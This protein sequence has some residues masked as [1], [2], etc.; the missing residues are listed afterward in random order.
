MNNSKATSGKG[1]STK[2]QAIRE[3]RRQEQRKQRLYI[4]LG[5]IAVALVIALILIIPGLMPAG[6]VVAITPVERPMVNGQ[7]LGDPNAPVKIDAYIDFQ[8]PSCKGYAEN[9]EME[10]IEKYVP[11]GDVY[12]TF[13]HY[14]FLDDNAVRKESDQAANASMCAGEQERF[15]DYHD[16]L[17]ANWDG[18]NQNAFSD[19]RLVAFAET[20]GLDLDA[21]N[22]CFQANTYKDAIE[23][24]IAAGK[25][26][27][28]TG[29]PS[30]F[31]N[32]E[33]L[34]PGY[35]PSFEQISQAVDAALAKS[36][37]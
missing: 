11:N 13:R 9:I 29:T 26:K 34:T 20:L 8:C 31:V 35:V 22:K 36:G 10:V 14:P 30:V 6:E 1:T 2:R 27:G 28:V 12:Y 21:F 7:S 23:S 24:D 5:I 32:G 37:N 25:M 18:E 17:F 15:W 19:K 4:I 3:K 16:M 33:Q